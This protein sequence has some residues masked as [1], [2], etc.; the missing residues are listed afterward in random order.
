MQE[1]GLDHTEEERCPS[2]GE[3]R[4]GGG[5]ECLTTV[6]G[7][8]LVCVYYLP[9]ICLRTWVVAEDGLGM[10]FIRLCTERVG[11]L[12]TRDVDHGWVGIAGDRALCPHVTHSHVTL[13][14]PTGNPKACLQWIS[15]SVL[16]LPIQ[17]GPRR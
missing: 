8:Y 10:G 2:L 9:C 14:S 16:S 5:K 3:G 13:L 11:R 1:V 17:G 4:G 12:W 15:T 7:K 6:F